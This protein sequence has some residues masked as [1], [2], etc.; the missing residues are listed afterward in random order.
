MVVIFMTEENISL[1]VL[2]HFKNLLKDILGFILTGKVQAGREPDYLSLQF[3]GWGRRQNL[4]VQRKLPKVSSRSQ[5]KTKEVMNTLLNLMHGKHQLNEYLA[6]FQVPLILQ[7]PQ[8]SGEDREVNLL[9]VADGQ[10]LTCCL[11]SAKG[12]LRRTEGRCV[13][14]RNRTVT[15]QVKKGKG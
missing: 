12:K 3:T 13:Y 2:S 4:K 10:I 15:P 1:N 9:Q 8:A 6:M 5:V 14:R 11:T 7:E